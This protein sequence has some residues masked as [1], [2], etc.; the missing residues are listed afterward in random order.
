MF[1]KSSK[2]R[3]WMRSN[4]FP[5]QRKRSRNHRS[6]ATPDKMQP[7]M[8]PRTS[9]QTPPRWTQQSQSMTLRKFS[10]RVSPSNHMKMCKRLKKTSI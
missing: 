9:M 8:S 4:R 5:Y 1:P 6:A 7:R 10:N 3:I 2:R